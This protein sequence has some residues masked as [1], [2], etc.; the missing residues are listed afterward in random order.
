MGQLRTESLGTLDCIDEQNH[1]VSNIIVG[2]EK[3]KPTDYLSGDI[4]INGKVVSKVYGTYLGYIE[5][6]GVRYWD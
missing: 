2:K 6:D 3:K 1:I 4:K 5:F